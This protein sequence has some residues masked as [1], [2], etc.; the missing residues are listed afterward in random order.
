MAPT[1]RLAR[2]RLGAML[3]V[4]KVP[5]TLT[6]REHLRLFSSYYPT[7]M[8][9][10]DV[11]ALAGLNG[12]ERRRFSTLSGGECQRVL[13]A[14]AICGKPD[15]LV[16]DEPTVGLDAESRRGFWRE[17]R[18]AKDRGCALLLTT[19][20]LE[21]AD[22]LADRIVVLQRGRTIADGSPATIKAQAAHVEIRCETALDEHQLKELPG[23]SHVRHLN[24]RTTIA[25]A[26]PEPALRE[27]LHRDPSVTGLEVSRATLEDAF[28]A[29]TTQSG[30]PEGRPSN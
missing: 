20:Y 24:G 21:E 2:E 15:L 1:E 29:L 13:F 10:A 4:S 6:V 25:V 27:L 14:L 26:T 5:E 9:E 7:P 11:V 28:L 17:I 19:H 8:A 30:R 22:A 12:L 18:R 3:Q 16:L 23:V